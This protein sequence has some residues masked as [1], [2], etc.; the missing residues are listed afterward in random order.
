MKHRHCPRRPTARHPQAISALTADRSFPAYCS[1]RRAARPSGYAVFDCET[2]GVVPSEDEIV[3]LALVL[4]DPDGVQNQRFGSLVR[5][6]VPIPAAASAVHGIHDEDVANAPTFVQ[7]AEGFFSLLESRVFV[8]HN[9]NFDLAILQHAF[10]NAGLDYRPASVAC[11]LAAFRILE[12]LAD[13]HRLEEICK[14][15]DIRSTT[16]MRL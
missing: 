1:T 12:P 11:T 8:A 4:L 9:A 6:S 3:S 14:R 5:T 7:M 2:T 13:N 15:H 16:H 10:E